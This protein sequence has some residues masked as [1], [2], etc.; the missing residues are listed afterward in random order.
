M[1]E[2]VPLL[3]HFPLLVLFISVHYVTANIA[4]S[5]EI[6]FI[7]SVV[8]CIFVCFQLFSGKNAEYVNKMKFPR[9]GESS[10]FVQVYDKLVMI[11][12]MLPCP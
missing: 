11:I 10:G 4:A 12:G 6:I 3:I 8:L 7:K 9:E 1:Y 2:P 5:I